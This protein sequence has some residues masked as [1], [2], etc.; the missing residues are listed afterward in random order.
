MPDEQPFSRIVSRSAELEGR[1]GHSTAVEIARDQARD[2]AHA[3]SGRIP[4][5][6]GWLRVLG[7]MCQVADEVGVALMSRGWPGVPRICG[8]SC[9]LGRAQSST[10]QGYRRLA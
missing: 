7:D 6:Y 2:N 9:T 4:L 5:R 8:P 10:D 1:L 3:L